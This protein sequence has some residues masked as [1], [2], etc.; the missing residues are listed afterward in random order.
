MKKVSCLTAT[1]GRY[2]VLTEAI[3]CFMAQDYPE[4]ELIILNNHQVKIV[5][6]LPQVTVIN[7]E[8][9]QSLGDCRNRLIELA[10]GDY[11]RTWDDDD[12][13]L[14]HAISQGVEHIKDYPAWKPLRSWGWRVDRDLMY[15]GGNAYEASWTVRA[16]IA[17]RFKYI[18]MSGGN[19]HNGLQ[20]GI[21]SLGGIRR[22]DVDPSYVYRWGTALCRISGSLNKNDLS[23]ETTAKRTERWKKLNDD[24]GN[25]KPIMPV[26]LTKYW[27]RIKRAKHELDTYPNEA[28][29]DLQGRSSLA[30]I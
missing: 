7:G 8:H 30:A 21:Q 24:H 19:E 18:P 14:P 20:R 29:K 15:L 9:Y 2:K 11:A 5:C 17:R 6:N 28:K 13:Y 16:E 4:R 27:E 26:D 22:D 25:E 1:Y 23:A 12:L 3:S 10:T